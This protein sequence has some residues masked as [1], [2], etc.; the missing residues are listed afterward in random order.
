MK[1][2][3]EVAQIFGVSRQT[4]LSWIDKGILKAS[5]P[6]RQYRIDEQEIERLKNKTKGQ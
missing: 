6:L 5:K 1:T 4:V 2:V 3:V